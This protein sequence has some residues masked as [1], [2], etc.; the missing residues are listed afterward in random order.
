M[1]DHVLTLPELSPEAAAAVAAATPSPVKRRLAGF[2]S[3][4]STSDRAA[5]TAAAGGSVVSSATASVASAP[6]A[7]DDVSSD[8]LEGVPDAIVTALAS[9]GSEGELLS[10]FQILIDAASSALP[11][12]CGMC[13]AALPHVAE[14]KGVILTAAIAKRE[15]NFDIW[16]TEV[17][18]RFG[19][20]LKIATDAHGGS[21]K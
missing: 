7:H 2:A 16:T 12:A 9:A 21:G 15:A 4:E 11:G 14:K 13:V 3:G 17:A 5:A 19:A 6:S 8:V 1:T 10:I 18:K 20:F